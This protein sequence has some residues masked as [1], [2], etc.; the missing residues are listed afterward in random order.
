MLLAKKETIVSRDELRPE[1]V[2]Q[3]ER[4]DVHLK[5]FEKQNFAENFVLNTEN[6]SVSEEVDEILSGRFLI[7]TA[8]DKGHCSGLKELYFN[9]VKSGEKIYELRVHDEKRQNINVGDD[10][11]F[12]LEPERNQM[13]RKKIKNKLLFKNFSEASDKL[14]FKKVGFSS[15]EEMKIV[16]NAIYSK[17]EQ[18]KFGVVAFELE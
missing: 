5:D 6:K 2:Q 3:A 13:V 16:Y 18:E 10:Y 9:M 1:D 7:Q 14:D 11:V 12:G 4:I 15:R 17:E 8:V